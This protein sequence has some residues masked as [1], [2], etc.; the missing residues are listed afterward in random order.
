MLLTEFLAPY[1]LTLDDIRGELDDSFGEALLVVATG[2]VLQGYGNSRSDIDLFVVVERD[3]RALPL[4]SFTK[5]AR[6]DTTFHTATTL[7]GQVAEARSPWP[8]QA[9][10]PQREW[11]RRK[12][13]LDT[14]TRFALSSVLSGSESWRAW[15]A[16]LEQPW[17]LDALVTW[18]GVEAVRRRQ[19]GRFFRD[20]NPFL[21]AQRYCE[22]TVAA[23]ERRA[24]RAGHLYFVSATGKWLPEK[25]L[26]MRD[27]SGLAACR[28][29]FSTPSPHYHE[30]AEEF[31]AAELA[32]LDHVAS[33]WA[34][35]LSVLDG[36]EAFPVGHS[37]VVARW[38]SRHVELPEPCEV[39]APAA[40]VWNGVVD[41]EPPEP[42]S[43]LLANDM[44]WVS[45]VGP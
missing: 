14:V 29:A 4:L 36:T 1:R 10:C 42:W 6:V 17:L 25:L 15:R 31:L 40:T 21:S 9:P 41:D 22:A 35:E 44:L 12:R 2:S 39:P 23:L 18:W 19:A 27:A 24:A 34:L 16:E 13:A 37:T 32:D 26:A 20:R 30:R 45:V 7:D 8:P 38:Q 11:V 43:T 33:R 5:G 3:V 28:E